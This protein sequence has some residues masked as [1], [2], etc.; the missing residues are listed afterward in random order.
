MMVSL[1]NHWRKRTL[2]LGDVNSGKT[3]M[4]LELLDRVIHQ[5]KDKV[6]VIDLAPEKTRGIGGKMEVPSHPRISYRTTRIIPP[7]LTGKSVDE[8][9]VYA[10]QNANAIE[11]L[12]SA[13]LKTPRKILVINDVSLY[14]QRGDLGR[15]LDVLRT[16]H[17]AIINGY[18]GKAL[19]DSAFSKREKR[20]MDR[21]A[22]ACDRVVRL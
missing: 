13:Y 1:E 18:Y 3:Q 6:A 14:L 10:L 15:L 5:K 17:T 7:R 4:T 12:F 19:G 22:E 20:Q 21:L 16:S 8:V 2:I 9:E 11:E